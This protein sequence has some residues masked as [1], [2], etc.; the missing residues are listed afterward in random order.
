MNFFKR[1]PLALMIS[2]CLATSAATAMLSSAMKVVLILISVGFVPLF[3][4]I[5]RRFGIKEICNVSSSAFIAAVSALTVCS[6]LLNY[7]YYD[8]YAGKYNKYDTATVR[9][10]IIGIEN[11]TSYSVVYSARL[12][13]VNGVPSQAKGLICS[14]TAIGLSP[15]D[16][17]EATAEFV[18]SEDFYRDYD[19]PRIRFL[20][21]GYVFTCNT[22]GTPGIV[23]K[24]ASLDAEFANLRDNISAKMSLC[25]SD[26]ASALANALFLGDRSGLEKVYRDFKNMGVV[27]L[28]ALS[29]LHLAVLDSMISKLLKAFGV[30]PKSRNFITLLFIIF[31]TALTGFLMSVMRAALMLILSRLAMFLNNRADRV[32]T[33][34]AACGLIVWVEPAAVFDVAL[35]MSFASTLGILLISEETGKLFAGVPYYASWRYTF[36]F[37]LLKTLEVIPISFAAAV[38]VLPLLWL[39]FGE[40]SLLSVP[41]TLIMA[42]FCEGL[43]VLIPIYLLFALTGLHSLGVGIGWLIEILTKIC[44]VIADLLA[45]VS[46]LV[47]LNYPF[48]LPI[49][50]VCAAVIILMMIKNVSSWLYALIPIGIS[51]II[52]LS[53]AAI[54]ETLHENDVTL[55]YISADSGDALIAVSGRKAMLIDISEGPSDIYYSCMDALA[56]NCII[57]IDT[58]LYTHI[59]RKHIN[60]LRGLLNKLVIRRILLP[61]PTGEYDRYI[62]LEI[63]ALAKEYGTEAIFYT[64]FEETEINFG[65]IRITLPKKAALNRS[66]HPIMTLLIEHNDSEIAYIGKSVWEDE[67]LWNEIKEAEYMILGGCGPEIKSFPDGSINPKTKVICIGDKTVL[68]ELSP[69]L[70]GFKGT[71]IREKQLKINLTP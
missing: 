7:A 2:I 14:E 62:T 29:G 19:M 59:H 66:T 57:E 69:W 41:A 63:A 15:G 22:D 70:D 5:V 45:S 30:R 65:D 31:Y 42:I 37:R 4:A 50:I 6:I 36:R 60:S 25:L 56:N 28:L 68:G 53:G 33:L 18:P 11:S 49:I 9:A 8:A 10:E 61:V 67:K 21:D 27:H 52:F 26:D 47:S 20:S 38:S 46:S 64:V 24:V 40:T 13:S 32:T 48:A 58:L 16:L 17:V 34:F 55:D 44:T 35:Q 3:I 1:R 23:G 71:I 12:Q 54:Y 39:Y 43:L 51:V